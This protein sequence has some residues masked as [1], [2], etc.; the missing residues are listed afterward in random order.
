MVKDTTN[1]THV[2]KKIATPTFNTL[3][4]SSIQVSCFRKCLSTWVT[5]VVFL[6]IM[7]WINVFLQGS[8]LRKWLST[9]VTFV[10]FLTIMNWINVSLQVSCFRKYLST[11]VTFEI[12]LKL[13]VSSN[14]VLG[15]ISFHMYH[16]YDLFEYCELN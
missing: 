9:W 1:V 5:F 7:N 16:I 10:V 6:T 13:C 11:G 3:T 15:K 2:V 4:L 12:F 8:C 14:S